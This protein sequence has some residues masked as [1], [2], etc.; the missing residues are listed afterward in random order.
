MYFDREGWV[1]MRFENTYLEGFGS[2]LPEEVVL[3]TDIEDQ[4]APLY[5]RFGLHQGRLELMSGI[6]ERRF[7]PRGTMPSE[8]SAEAGRRA[9]SASKTSA[10]QIECLLHTSVSR[11]CLEPATAAF[12]HRKLGLKPDVSMFDISNACLGFLNGMVVL[13]NMIELGQVKRGMI[14]AGESSRQLV[15]TTINHLLENE[16]LTRKDFKSAFAS[17]TIGSGAVAL[18][19]SHRSV[20]ESGHRLLGGAVRASSDD[21][22]LCRGTADTGFSRDATMVMNTDSETLLEAGC[23]LAVRTWAI[24]KEQLGW[25]NDSVDRVF[26]H[27]VGVAHRDRLYDVL[28]LDPSLDFST[29]EF[30]GNVGSVSLPIT[31]ALGIEKNMPKTGENIAMMGIGS[32][33]NCIALGVQW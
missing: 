23:E 13:A 12:V 22:H 16:S 8:V 20:S 15:E 24:A 33:L 32:G 28:K 30:L 11:D 2:V 6:A 3:S 19:M 14:V 1:S 21:N 4:L 18:V 29:L 7:W 9:L 25:H 17:L 26:T 5:E 31:M 10:D 27:Q